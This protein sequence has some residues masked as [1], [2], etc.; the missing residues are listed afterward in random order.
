M[1][2][3]WLANWEY[4]YVFEWVSE[5]SKQL[6]KQHGY[7]RIEDIDNYGSKTPVTENK[8][9]KSP[10][11]QVYH[12]SL[13]D[14]TVSL[15]ST[16][17]LNLLS[18]G[19]YTLVSH[20]WW[21]LSRATHTYMKIFQVKCYS[22]DCLKHLC[23]LTLQEVLLAWIFQDKCTYLA[24]FPNQGCRLN[25]KKRRSGILKERKLVFPSAESIFFFFFQNSNK[26]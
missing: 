15:C 17:Q 26:F 6:S 1:D 18:L 25:C 7:R 24:M 9:T 22:M 3:Y 4:Q 2:I 10:T 5:V 13:V 12:R 21:N 19:T 20:F 16:I 23:V 14:L 8:K 11:Y